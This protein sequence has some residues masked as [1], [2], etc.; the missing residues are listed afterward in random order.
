M[1]NNFRYTTLVF[2]QRVEGN[3]L[4]FNIVFLPR[5]RD[6]FKPMDTGVAA[7]PT[8]PAF[9]DLVPQFEAKIVKGL[10]SFPVDNGS[11]E[12]P[13]TVTVTTS[14]PAKKAAL[15][16]AIET[17]FGDRINNTAA[18]KAEPPKPESLTVKKYLP[19]SYRGAFNF[20]SPR[21][22]NAVTD[23]SY[24][25]AIRD[26]KPNNAPTTVDLLSWGKIFGYILRQPFLAEACGFVYKTSIRI[27]PAWFEKGGYLY[28]DLVN[29]DH[30]TV[31][32]ASWTI[33]ED[34]SF[35]KRFAAR[36]PKLKAGENRSL[37]APV[38]FPVLHSYGGLVTEPKAPW[39][40]IF[41]EVNAYD[42]GFAKIVHSNQPVS[43]NLL[44]EKYD[45]ANPVHDAG[46]RL[47]WDDEQLLIWYVRQM[48][49]N[50]DDPGKRIETPLGVFGYRIDVRQ[51][52]D[53]AWESLNTIITSSESEYKIADVSV[54]N[55]L[56]EE[57]ELP[58]QVYPSQVD[59]QGAKS[60]WLPMYFTN[61]IGKSLVMKDD[62]AARIY[63]HDDA[64]RPVSSNQVFREKQVSFKL[65][66]GNTYFFRVRLCD[67]SNGGPS[68][69][70]E[71]SATK[72]APNPAEKVDF[73]RYIEP[74]KLRLSDLDRLLIDST[75]ENN[76]PVFKNHVDFYNGSLA[77]GEEVFDSNPVLNLRRPLLGYPAVLF[78]GKYEETDA[79]AKLRAIADEDAD[80]TN[81]NASRVGLG[82]ADPDVTKVEIIVEVETL[83]M[84]NLLSY[85]GQENYAQLYTTYRNFD[86]AD[87]DASLPVRFT[88]VDAPNLNLIDFDS[89]GSDPF[90]DPGLLKAGLDARADVVVPTARKIRITMRAVCEEDDV[91]FGSINGP[92]EQQTRFGATTQIFL[93]KESFVEDLLL[94]PWQTVPVLQGIYLQPD[95]PVV[96]LGNAM[97]L[98]TRFGTGNK[99]NIVQRLAKQLG[100]E[101]KGLTLTSNKGQRIV[102]GCSSRIRH[103][104]APDLSSITFA[105]KEDLSDHWLGCIV[106]RLNRDWSWDALEDIAFSF[107]RTKKFLNDDDNPAEHQLVLGD[108]EMK[109]AVSFE[110]L[111]ADRFGLVNRNET[112]F[113]FI[114]AI[115]PKSVFKRTGG[116]LRFP[117]ELQVEYTVKARFKRE[118]GN[119]PELLQ[120]EK[121]VL[122][123][124]I[125]PAQVPTLASVGLAFS[126]YLI[127]GNYE[128]TEVRQR[129]LWLE[130]TEPIKDPNDTLFCRMLA[131][132]PDQ[133]ISNNSFEM[134]EAPEEPPLPID[135][136]YIRVITPNQTPDLAGLSAMQV[137]TKS[138]DSDL[139][140]LMPIPPGMHSESAE[141]FG[142]FT[143]E[144]RVGHAYRADTK[145]NLWST[146]QAR[147][148]RALR[149][150]GMQHPAPNLMCVVNRDEEKIYVNAPYA[151]AVFNGKNVT[152]NPPRTQL[153]CLL[154]A[155]VHQADRKAFRNIL[156]DDRYMDWKKKVTRELE[157]EINIHDTYKKLVTR[158]RDF[159]HARDYNIFHKP[160]LEKSKIHAQLTAG[161]KL[162]IF[163]DQQR[164]G[165]ATWENKEVISLLRQYGL[166]EDSSLSVITVEVFGNITNIKEHL[167]KLFEP[168]NQE[169]TYN[170]M[171]KDMDERAAAGFKADVRKAAA[172]QEEEFLNT[173]RLKPLSSGLGHY[174]ILRTSPLTKVP[175]V[176]CTDC[177]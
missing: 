21:H 103:S 47:G 22:K 118:H 132:A 110:A 17:S 169:A 73:K 54:G 144:L 9:A 26:S 8:T 69:T 125:N 177:D 12:L 14:A 84:D 46:I 102:F 87:Y 158:E 28:V 62:T 64:N 152:A 59:G 49:E 156:L 99:P 145:D 75:D 4:F 111:Q 24:H 41:K 92:K 142:F 150:T 127:D 121:L 171:A 15:L 129:Y 165:L 31:Q 79:L 135:P 18:D 162:A 160:S 123:T 78:T 23:D 126:P 122:P 95:A 80:D 157:T 70:D 66:Y 57:I 174:R 53:D 147:F 77:A 97:D 93:Y 134:M 36:I 170:R 11:P 108:I 149:V 74:G 161:A 5:N 104:L 98:F 117:D 19:L 106:Y 56:N 29:P 90:N 13:G 94:Q 2:P 172:Q 37:F 176:C 33:P 131:Y 137:L 82:I 35:V 114:D 16:K 52:M 38:L 136:E 148:G 40:N 60:F 139:H 65:V 10:E 101:S 34:G 153:W 48:A 25:C 143:Y 120:P 83:K 6:P 85:T 91:Y 173:V 107:E 116:E 154:Y 20:T 128:R 141:L 168:R 67:L 124:T 45:G 146:A 76:L 164:T 43:L 96:K 163:K 27:E 50:P 51:R 166:P 100:I 61:W 89:E 1:N 175:F 130:L 58:Y 63:K 72:Q 39:D 55:K 3:Q 109:S 113:I 68:V 155:Q 71:M 115:E 138:T 32:N 159:L 30:V 42:D 140:Y 86:A 81:T 88:F 167:S 7:F 119:N 112:I 133:L 105:S 44:S 151:Q